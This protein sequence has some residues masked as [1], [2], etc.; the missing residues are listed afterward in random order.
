MGYVYFI[1]GDGFLVSVCLIVG[2]A[3]LGFLLWNYPYGLI[4]LGD[5]L[6]VSILAPAIRRKKEI[7]DELAAEI[8]KRA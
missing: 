8:K 2:G 3:I 1:V 4:F 7:E 6:G 5:G